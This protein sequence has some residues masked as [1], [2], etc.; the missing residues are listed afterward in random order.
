MEELKKKYRWGPSFITN[1]PQRI[2]YIQLMFKTFLVKKN[3]LL[4]KF[5]KFLSAKIKQF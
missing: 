1:I 5:I 4:S 3:F 2:I